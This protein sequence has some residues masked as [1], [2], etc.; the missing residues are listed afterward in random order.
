MEERRKGFLSVTRAKQM[1]KFLTIDIFEYDE[2]THEGFNPNVIYETPELE[3]KI[4]NYVKA[5]KELENFL[6]LDK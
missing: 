3:E 1:A 6:E 4:K 5:K 2:E